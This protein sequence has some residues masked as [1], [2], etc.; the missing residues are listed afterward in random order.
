MKFRLSTFVD[1][2]L[3]SG[4]PLDGDPITAFQAVP[5]LGLRTATVLNNR[6]PMVRDVVKVRFMATNCGKRPI[7][8]VRCVQA[9]RERDHNYSERNATTLLPGESLEYSIFRSWDAP[10]ERQ[11]TMAYEA[12]C[13]GH[14]FARLTYPTVALHVTAPLTPW[15][16]WTHAA[17]ARFAWQSLSHNLL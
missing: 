6:R 13:A 14:P 8:V 1:A 16:L 15:I 5:L 10:G 12:R 9:D 11:L 3:G 7:Q 4:V 17:R 2:F